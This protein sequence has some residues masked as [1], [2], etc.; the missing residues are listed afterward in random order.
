MTTYIKSINRK[1][2]KLVKTKIEIED[3]ENPTAAKEVLLQNNGIA[4]SAIHDA[5]DE[6][7]FKKIKNFDMAHEA[8]KKLEESFEGTQ[9]VKGAKAYILKEKF[10]RFMMKEDESVPE[11]FHKLQVLVNDLKVLGEEVKDND[12]SHKFLRCLPSRF[13]TLVTILVRSGLDTK[14]PKQVLGDVMTDDTY[15]DDEEKEEKNKDK[16]DEKKDEKKKSVAFKASSSSKGKAK[17]ETSSEDDDS[18]FDEMDDEKMA[19]F[20]KRFV[21]FMVKKGYRARRKKSSSKN[22]EEARRCFKCNSKDNLI[23][24]CLHR[25]GQKTNS[26]FRDAELEF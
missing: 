6:R 15:R 3:P 22:K 25:Q 12:F 8:W 9:A 7:T 11:M 10:A 19:L 20:L 16:K 17:Q 2:W 24:E 14:T 4:L 18:S 1:M 21:K 26:N 13:G 5:L 23:A